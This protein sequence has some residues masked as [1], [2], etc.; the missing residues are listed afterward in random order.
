MDSAHGCIY[1]TLILLWIVR[2]LVLL[3]AVSSASVAGQDWH[4][5]LCT[6]SITTNYRG[7][8]PVRD[9][10]MDVA[11]VASAG[12]VLVYRRGRSW[13]Q[14]CKEKY[15]SGKYREIISTY[16][17]RSH[18]KNSSSNI[19]RG[20]INNHVTANTRHWHNVDL[21]LVQRRRRWTNIR[22]ALATPVL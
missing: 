14:L 19:N 17:F 10:G 1:T 21:I 12:P 15:N 2:F 16:Y 22:P 6:P 8:R 9:V 20:M 11:T 3:L 4:R 5:A 7:T 13:N 18:R